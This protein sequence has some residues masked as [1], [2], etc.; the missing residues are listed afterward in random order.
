MPRAVV[1]ATLAVDPDFLAG[2]DA[3]GRLRLFAPDPVDPGSSISHWDA[4]ATPDLL[5]EPAISGGVAIGDLDLTLDQLRDIG[6]SPGSS[7]VVVHFRDAQGEG[8]FA[9]EPIGLTRRA[10]MEHVADLWGGLLESGITIHVDAAFDDL[11]C[12]DDGA[13]LARAGPVFI[14]ESFAGADVQS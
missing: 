8:F 3:S 4:V 5:M 1:A 10:A 2:A 14:Y 12:G 7:N 9:P 13:V 11:D 6:W